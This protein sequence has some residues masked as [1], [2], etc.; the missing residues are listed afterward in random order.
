MGY[1]NERSNI[2]IVEAPVLLSEMVSLDKATTTDAFAFG[3]M[4]EAD[5]KA[6][7]CQVAT[8]SDLNSFIGISMSVS[9]AAGTSDLINVALRGVIEAPLASTATA[10]YFGNA[11]AY[12]AGQNGT[13]WTLTNTASKAMFH[14]LSKVLAASG[15]GIFLFD[16]Y[17]ARV[18]TNL[19]FF[20]LPTA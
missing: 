12:S 10:T 20:E 17:S 15:T 19:S 18:I 1:L 7:N 3:D 8:T 9:L 5:T 14:C 13:T 16:Q 6:G 4:I 11:V 2:R